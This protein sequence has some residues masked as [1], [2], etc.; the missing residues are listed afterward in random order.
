MA[1]KIYA[2]YPSTPKDLETGKEKGIYEVKKTL[3]EKLK[4]TVN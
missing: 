2:K 4:I 1:L 3:K